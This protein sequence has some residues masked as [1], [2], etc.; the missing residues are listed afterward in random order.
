[1]RLKDKI[2][3]RILVIGPEYLASKEISDYLTSNATIFHKALIQ[4]FQVIPVSEKNSLVTVAAERGFSLKR[5]HDLQFTLGQNI[6]VIFKDKAWIDTALKQIGVEEIAND[7]FRATSEGRRAVDG[8]QR[9]E[10]EYSKV[11]NKYDDTPTVELVNDIINKAIKLNA[12]DIH[13][14]PLEK[15][16]RF[17]YRL[18][19][20][21]QNILSLPMEK[22][23]AIISRLKIMADLDIAEKRRPQDGRI[24]HPSTPLRMNGE[25]KIIDIRVSTLPTDFTGPAAFSQPS[26]N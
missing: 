15:E 11:T 26:V 21:L 5:L 14:E 23:A 24:R 6:K 8:K 19:G 7:E 3:D 1:M 25:S 22:K 12:S 10:K 20:V 9:T 2:N 13:V 4:A 16:L 17:R 18:D